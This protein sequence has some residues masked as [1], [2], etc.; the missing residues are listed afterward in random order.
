MWNLSHIW[1]LDAIEIVDVY[2][3]RQHSWELDRQFFL[4]DRLQRRH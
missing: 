4:L 1:F 3:A 2:H